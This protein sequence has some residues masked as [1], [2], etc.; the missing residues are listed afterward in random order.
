V[1]TGRAKDQINRGG[2]KIAAAEVEQV[3]LAHE[4]VADAAVVSIPDEH[5]GERSCAYVVAR[6]AVPP[7]GSALRAHVRRAGLAAFKIPDK[8]VFVA[9]LPRTAV[10]K[11]DKKALRDRHRKDS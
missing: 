5:L 4:A 10:G 11:V 6:D 7:K 3:L 9:A 8:V 2:E 1:V